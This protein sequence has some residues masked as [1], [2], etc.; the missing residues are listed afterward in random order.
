VAI[1]IHWGTLA[2]PLK[3][4]RPADPERPARE[5]ESLVARAAP[6]VEVRVLGPGEHTT[7]D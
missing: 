5:F 6:Q 7:V 2:L 1:P 4:A 3:R